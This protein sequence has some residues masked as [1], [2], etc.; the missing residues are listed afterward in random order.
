MYLCRVLNNYYSTMNHL[1]SQMANQYDDSE[2]PAAFPI[3]RDPSLITQKQSVYDVYTV[4]KRIYEKVG[5][6]CYE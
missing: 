4:M 6:K 1:D 5:D 3:L 2:I